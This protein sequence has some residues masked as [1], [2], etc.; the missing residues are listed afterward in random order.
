M[1]E[2]EYLPLSEAAPLYSLS[3]D[4][5]R[6]RILAGELSGRQERRGGRSYW[7][8]AR[9]L[10][11]AVAE[12]APSA[13]ETELIAV[14]RAELDAW[15]RQA[16]ARER[17]VAELHVLLQRALE[18]PAL[19]APTAR[20]GAGAPSEVGQASPGWWREFREG[21]RG[22]GA[23]LTLTGVVAILAGIGLH[24]ALQRQVI[25]SEVR[26]GYVIGL[27]GLLTLLIGLVLV[28]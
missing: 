1:S 2:P 21:K 6:R 18:R 12:A 24:I 14:L 17:E 26:L 28:F 13:E 7:V 23:S 22:L 16:E 5:L 9:P 10:A 4:T 27:V 19:P 15:R 20:Q 8:V 25:E 11:K 3:V